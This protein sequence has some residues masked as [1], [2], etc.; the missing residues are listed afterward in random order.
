[1]HNTPLGSGAVDA[2]EAGDRGLAR[3][4]GTR[5]VVAK[6]SPESLWKSTA[7]TS[8]DNFH[9]IHGDLMAGWSAPVRALGGGTGV[10]CA[11]THTE[12]GWQD[13]VV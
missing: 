10:E 3:R 5:G 2:G 6:V 9:S 1:M 4:G 7:L 8:L 12:G 11:K 13:M